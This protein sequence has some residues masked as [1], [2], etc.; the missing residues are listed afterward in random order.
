M[1]RKKTTFFKSKHGTSIPKM[2]VFV[3]L[4]LLKNGQNATAQSSNLLASA[5][6]TSFFQTKNTFALK[7]ILTDIGEHYKVKIAYETRLIKDL[8]V[9]AYPSFVNQDVVIVLRK[10][11]NEVNLD[12]EKVTETILVVKP[13]PA[14]VEATPLV[15]SKKKKKQAIDE[16]TVT[17]TVRDVNNQGIPGVNVVIEGT[18][19]GTATNIEGNYQIGVSGPT[20]VLIFSSVGMETVKETVGSRTTIDVV[21]KDEAKA[22]EMVIVTALGFTENRDKQGSTSSKVD[23]KSVVR[24]GESGVLQGLAGKASGVRITRSTGDPGAGSNFQI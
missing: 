1:N 19:K 4:L 3:I 24:S 2:L 12:V 13:K 18:A 8:S 21:L 7:D 9:D 11:L 10:V 14:A 22:L 16:Q 17:G 20:A 23:P 5:N 15:V 6:P